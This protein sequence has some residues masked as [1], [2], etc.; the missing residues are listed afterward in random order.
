MRMSRLLR[1]LSLLV[2]FGG[3]ARA[4]TV[5]IINF[6]DLPPLSQPLEQYSSL[7]LHFLPP[8]A[9]GVIQGI[10]NGDPGN[11]SLDGTVGPYFLGFNSTSGFSQTITIDFPVTSV[12]VDVSRAN[13]SSAADTFTLNAYNSSIL[14]GTQTLPLTTINVWTTVVLSAP[15][16]TSINLSTSGSGTP[17]FGVDHIQFNA[18]PEPSTSVL[19]VAGLLGVAWLR[20]GP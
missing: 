13:G 4:Q 11:W 7:G 9:F 10:S 16:I 19:L 12:A 8:G 17:N 14:V 1:L 2:L 5:V 15:A 18:I 3:V 6:D 20:R